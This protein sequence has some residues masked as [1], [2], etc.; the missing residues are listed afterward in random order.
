MEEVM[1]EIMEENKIK[2]SEVIDLRAVF[3]KIWDNRRLFYKVL[4]I[5]FVLSCIFIFSIPRY[6]IS[7][8]KIICIWKSSFIF[9]MNIKYNNMRII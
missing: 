8:I 2:D 5:V 3:I 1:K 6:Y 4:P 9:R 7:N